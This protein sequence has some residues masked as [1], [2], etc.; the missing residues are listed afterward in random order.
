MIHFLVD[1]L[2]HALK[3]DHHVGSVLG[4]YFL[5][6]VIGIAAVSKDCST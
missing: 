6:D 2:S 5:P 1:R 3:S 4:D